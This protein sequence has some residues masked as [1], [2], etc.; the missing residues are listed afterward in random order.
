MQT[1]T[2]SS[3]VQNPVLNNRGAGG[4]QLDEVDPAALIPD[5]DNRFIDTEEEDFLLFVEDIKAKGILQPLLVTKNL[6]II[7]GHRRREGAIKAGLKKVPVIYRELRVGE[8]TGDYFLAENQQRKGLTILEEAVVLKRIKDDTGL[9]GKDLARRVN[10][11]AEHVRSC[12]RLLE[13]DPQVQEYFHQQ[14]LP[15]NSIKSFYKL[16][17]SPHE[18]VKYANLFTIGKLTVDGFERTLVRLEAANNAQNAEAGDEGD[19][20]DQTEKRNYMK[21]IVSYGTQPARQVSREETVQN[22]LANGSNTISLHLV[23]QVL[24]STCCYCGMEEEK[25]LCSTCPT[26]VFANGLLGRSKQNN[27]NFE[28]ELEDD[29]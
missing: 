21:S 1:D 6:N 22:L 29:W 9:S 10:R 27:I 18:Q 28:Q 17:D 13:L 8:S 2:I 15:V 25:T 16:V 26:L 5:P 4:I 7:A 20:G 3:S 12:L 24:D 11:N 14:K 19:D 23:K